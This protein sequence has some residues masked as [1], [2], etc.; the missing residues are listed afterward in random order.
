MKTRPSRVKG[1][2]RKL[3]VALMSIV[4]DKENIFMIISL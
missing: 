2:S 4:E 1:Y 3:E